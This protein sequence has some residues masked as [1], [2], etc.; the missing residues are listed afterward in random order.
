MFAHDLHFITL[1]TSL[2]PSPHPHKQVAASV[3][4]RTTIQYGM[5]TYGQR[6][7]Q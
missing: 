4:Q 5:Q 6:S 1:K 7:E 2:P 3:T